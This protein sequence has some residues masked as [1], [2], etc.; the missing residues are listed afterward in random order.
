MMSL[1]GLFKTPVGRNSL[2]AL[3][4]SFGR[5][6]PTPDVKLKENALKNTDRFGH[7]KQRA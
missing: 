3:R 1:C 5:T 7:N 6:F 4:F 2:S